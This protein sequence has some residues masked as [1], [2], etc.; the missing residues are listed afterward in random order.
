MIVSNIIRNYLAVWGDR[1]RG[2]PADKRQ[3][4]TI[5]PTAHREGFPILRFCVPYFGVLQTQPPG[6]FYPERSI[7]TEPPGGL[8]AEVLTADYGRFCSGGDLELG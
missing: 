7:W 8:V 3:G 2:A 5:L 4:K 6:G 1:K